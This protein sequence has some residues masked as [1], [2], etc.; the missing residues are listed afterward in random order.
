MKGSPRRLRQFKLESGTLVPRTGFLSGLSGL[1][2]GIWVC[3]G[4]VCFLH[5]AFLDKDPFFGAGKNPEPTGTNT[6]CRI[7]Q[8]N[9]EA[10]ALRMKR[11]CQQPEFESL[12]TCFECFRPRQ[13][14]V[15]LDID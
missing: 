5:Y 10:Q 4:L 11:Q 6:H 7:I 2:I 1:L 8:L 13:C 15:S 9:S 3:R 14:F 12:P